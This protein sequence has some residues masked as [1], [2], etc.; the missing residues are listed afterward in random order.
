MTTDGRLQLLH[1]AG[2]EEMPAKVCVPSPDVDKKKI[3]VLTCT[4]ATNKY[5]LNI[6][7]SSDISDD[8]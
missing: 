5:E 4:A 8:V 7:L 1:W 2:L 6:N 3:E